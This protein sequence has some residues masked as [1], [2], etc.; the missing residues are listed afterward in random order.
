MRE[1]LVRQ[2]FEDHIRRVF[3]TKPD[4]RDFILRHERR[5]LF[6]GNLRREIFGAEMKFGAKMNLNRV[7]LLVEAGGTIFA[8]AA[9]KEW[10]KR[11]MSAAERQLVEQKAN[12]HNENA[13]WYEEE[14]KD[15][16]STAVKASMF[17]GTKP[18]V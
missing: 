18:A 5:G 2:Y 6:E 17:T 8:E 16:L 4:I 15:A 1:Q 3:Q 13:A 12:R 10:Q 14:K 7:R 9:M 11:H